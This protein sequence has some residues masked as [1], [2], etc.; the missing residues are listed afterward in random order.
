[1]FHEQ[2]P[3]PVPCYDLAHVT[4]LTLTQPQ[5]YNQRLSTKKDR[6]CLTVTFVKHN[7]S[8]KTGAGL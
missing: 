8:S 3:L 1:M 5:F 2:L 4:E 6:L 7:V